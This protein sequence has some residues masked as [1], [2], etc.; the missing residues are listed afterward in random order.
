[1]ERNDN[2]AV[3]EI[4]PTPRV[5]IAFHGQSLGQQNVMSIQFDMEVRDPSP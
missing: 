4:P 3:I 1:M 2:A 5:Q